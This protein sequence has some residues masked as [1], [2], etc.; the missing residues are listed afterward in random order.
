[1]QDITA[2]PWEAVSV[3][4]NVAEYEIKNAAD[5]TTAYIIME[6]NINNKWKIR[7]F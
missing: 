1:M 6:T 7:S 4:E 2:A 5:E 3:G